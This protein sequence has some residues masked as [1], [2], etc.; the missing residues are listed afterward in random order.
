MENASDKKAEVGELYQKFTELLTN[1]HLS[2]DEKL[3]LSN[4]ILK[5]IYGSNEEVF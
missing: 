1:S 4:E 3:S 5:V 2:E